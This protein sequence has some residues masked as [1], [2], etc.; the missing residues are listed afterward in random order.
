MQR[1]LL[2]PFRLLFTAACACT[3][4]IPSAA[5]CPP[6]PPPP[7]CDIDSQFPGGRWDISQITG[8][9]TLSGSEVYWPFLDDEELSDDYTTN[10]T[11][12]VQR[13]GGE[14]ENYLEVECDGTV[15]GQGRERLT[16]TI[17]K[18]ANIWYYNSDTCI[19]QPS[20]MSWTVTIER[21]YSI[22][23]NVSG[24]GQL[25]LELSVDQATFD[26]DGSLAA[27][28]D[29]IFIRGSGTVSSFDVSGD[30]ESVRFSGAPPTDGGSWQPTVTPNGSKTW[31]DDVLH[32]LKL[33]M[34]H[35]YQDDTLTLSPSLTGGSGGQPARQEYL[36]YLI[37]DAVTVS[38]NLQA[39]AEPKTPVITSMELQ[40]PSR[41]L[42]DVDVD[43]EVRVS[44]DWR[45][46]S[47]GQV[48]FTYGSTTETVA[49]ADEVTW[50]FDAGESGTTIE[51]KA[52]AGS[53]ESE[54]YTINTPKVS[55]PSWAGSS[56]DW[57]GSSGVQYDGMLDWPVSLETT[58][59]LNTIELFTGLWGISGGASS[60][61]QAQANSNGSPGSGEMTT[62]ADIQFA[63][64]SA[65]FRM[66]GPNTTTLECDQLTTTGSA[67]AQ[68]DG[69]TWQKT[70]NPI[71]VVPGIE[72]GACGLSGLLCGVVRSVGVKAS[73][74]VTLDGTA[75]YTG[76]AGDI[77]WDGGSLGGSITGEI[78]A[79][80]TLPP[81]I[82]SAAGVRVWGSATGCLEFQ[83]APSLELTTV[84]GELEAGASATFMGLSTEATETW[85][86]G[87]GCSRRA[88]TRTGAES[89]WVP[90]DGQLAMAVDLIDGEL[91]GAAV[92]SELPDGQARPSGD[93]HYRI[94][95][96]GTWGPI[97]SLTADAASD[98]APT[99]A[100]D[101]D[102]DLLIVHQRSTASLPTS[103]AD[104]PTFANSYELHW[105]RVS[106]TSELPTATGV[107]TDDALHDVGPR[108]RRGASGDLHLFWQR[109]DGVE[110]AG[111]ASAPASIH[112]ASWQADD[113]S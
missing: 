67:T 20:D 66:E 65:S 82:A 70:L 38:E 93:I 57:S 33:S 96:G 3:I 111:T 58:Q 78:S 11:L 62:E 95:R 75:T 16:G 86:F 6:D 28:F 98:V 51:A 36:E 19:N 107:L 1:S 85:P 52:I 24:S 97:R 55:L 9:Y 31:V 12:D 2:L 106:S 8:S 102:G 43:T 84:G 53:E 72:A 50:T 17:S 108:W 37:Q 39:T 90:G 13:M 42:S 59:T 83:V 22:T 91:F 7:T 104:L 113:G 88:A 46:A 41:Y 23:G 32:R 63:G 94:V 87:S 73:A 25:D 56:S 4:A 14:S 64:N 21:T 61:F 74:S 15:T 26:L 99:V 80:A 5:T 92:W 100:I 45:S 103:V 27:S 69:P 44:I 60:D 40:E 29:C 49:G 101:A 76:E 79:G 89:G 71:T 48:E 34:E 77:E 68:V 110:L 35:E 10:G 81:P 54:P 105:A 18:T 112:V 109:V 30:T 47:P